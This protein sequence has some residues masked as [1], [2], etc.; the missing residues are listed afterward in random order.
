MFDLINVFDVFLPQLLMY[1]NPADPLNPEAGQMLYSAQDKYYDRI[2]EYIKKYAPR[3]VKNGFKAKT[4]GKAK[5]LKNGNS[6][7]KKIKKKKVLVTE[8]E[9]TKNDKDEDSLSD[10]ISEEM[11]NASELS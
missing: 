9:E 8:D 7:L 11:S 2:Q 6:K 4:N 10:L 5:Y 1:P 3:P